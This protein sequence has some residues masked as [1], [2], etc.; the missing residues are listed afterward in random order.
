MAESLKI[1][2]CRAQS[3][4]MGT[5]V[6]DSRVLAAMLIFVQSEVLRLDWP[7]EVSQV[8]FTFVVFLQA[9]KTKLQV[10]VD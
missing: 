5:E 4:V 1:R 8:R 7:E 10:R 6:P 3:E 2:A 9:F